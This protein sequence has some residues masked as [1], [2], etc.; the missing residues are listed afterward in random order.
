MRV[1][2]ERENEVK[3][4]ACVLTKVLSRS[5]SVEMISDLLVAVHKRVKVSRE[6]KVAFLS[7]CSAGLLSLT[8]FSSAGV[9]GT[10]STL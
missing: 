9:A 1:R 7:P 8:S 6:S 4:A 5:C 10:F 2:D 3:S